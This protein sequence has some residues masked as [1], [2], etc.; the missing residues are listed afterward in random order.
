MQF[1]FPIVRNAKE[2]KPKNFLS[3]DDKKVLK[4]KKSSETKPKLFSR[5]CHW[6]VISVAPNKNKR[7]AQCRQGPA[8][9]VK[10]FWAFP[11][12]LENTSCHNRVPGQ[13]S[14]ERIIEARLRAGPARRAGRPDGKDPGGHWAAQRP[15]PSPPAGPKPG[16]QAPQPPPGRQR[17]PSRGPH[18][19]FAPAPAASQRATRGSAGRRRK[20][21]RRTGSALRKPLARRSCF[22]EIGS[23]RFHLLS[24]PRAG[25]AAGTSF[26]MGLGLRVRPT[27]GSWPHCWPAGAA[28]TATCALRKPGS[29][30][31]R[32]LRPP[33]KR[34]GTDQTVTLAL[35]CHPVVRKGI[36]ALYR[37]VLSRI[38][39]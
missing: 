26:H 9:S 5:S 33:K 27:C 24:L 11:Q 3:S 10:V 22:R 21:W 34:V 30:E 7:R 28:E 1:P 18:A 25:P 12:K 6:H 20:R 35:G 36:A 32:K 38:P 2:E 23:P 13:G 29:P 31:T 14:M 17:G 37:N 15:T 8:A 4:K 16:S 39:F 19:A